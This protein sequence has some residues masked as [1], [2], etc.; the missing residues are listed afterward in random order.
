MHIIF[1]GN[2]SHGHPSRP[3]CGWTM[4]SDI[5]LVAIWALMSLCPCM[6]AQATQISMALGVTNMVACG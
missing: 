1:D 5:V 3:G 6:A 2:G 4:D